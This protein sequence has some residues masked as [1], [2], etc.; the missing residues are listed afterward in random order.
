MPNE[1]YY[2]TEVQNTLNPSGIPP[3]TLKLKLNTTAII[4][5][6]LNV[7]GGLC[8]GSR[9]KIRGLKPNVLIVELLSGENKGTL[10]FIP[11]VDCVPSEKGAL[12]FLL[13]RHQ[14]PIQPSYSMT[15]NKSQ[16]QTYDRVG[17]LLRKPVFTHGQLYVAV[18]RTKSFS[19]LKLEIH[20]CSG[21]PSKDINNAYTT[22]IVYPEALA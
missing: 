16:G 15:I 13:K 1:Q 21:Q 9:I 4:V 18:S 17:V 12:P 22:N 6:N 8:N 3:H 11:R 20:E 14:F 2:S 19:S 7:Q 5:R 10:T